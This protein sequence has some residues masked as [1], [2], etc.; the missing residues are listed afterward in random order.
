MKIT[1]G[2]HPILDAT[3]AGGKSFVP[4]SVHLSREGTRALVVTGPN[5][6]GKSCF[7]RQVA[8]IAVMAG[9]SYIFLIRP[10]LRNKSVIIATSSATF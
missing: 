4:N 1:D 10:I 9:T 2:R 3:L 6:G 7:I 8:L 5:M